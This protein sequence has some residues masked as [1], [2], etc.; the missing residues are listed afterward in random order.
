PARSCGM[1]TIENQWVAPPRLRAGSGAYPGRASRL[2]CRRR[3]RNIHT[4]R[5][6][7]ATFSENAM[8]RAGLAGFALAGLA[9]THAQKFDV[10]AFD[11]NRVL[12][13]ANKYLSEEPITITA[14][15]SPRSGGGAHDFFSEGD[16]WWP[17]PQ[18]PDGPY[19]QRDGMTN[20]DNFTDH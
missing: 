3:S 11:R 12:K 2:T 7:M 10:A 18:N 15:S 8:L 6:M 16:Y 9:A 19:I 4:V 13:A 20:P 17:D 14:S 1:G 5:S